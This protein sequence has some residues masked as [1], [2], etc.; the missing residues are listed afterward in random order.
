MRPPYHV[1]EAHA[2]RMRSRRGSI[3]ALHA[4]LAGGGE[5]ERPQLQRKRS[6]T[7]KLKGADSK[8]LSDELKKKMGG[9]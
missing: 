5:T 3:A 9:N 2:S 6:A 8:A 1:T 7:I 4:Q